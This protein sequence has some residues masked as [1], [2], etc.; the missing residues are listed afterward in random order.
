MEGRRYLEYHSNRPNFSHSRRTVGG[1][2]YL[3]WHTSSLIFLSPQG[4]QS[5]ADGTLRISL[6][7]SSSTFS[8]LSQAAGH[9]LSVLY[10]NV[11]STR[12]AHI[13]LKSVHIYWTL[14]Y[15]LFFLLHYRNE[16]T[17]GL[18]G[19]QEWGLSLVTF[20]TGT[21]YHRQPSSP[22]CNRINP[23]VWQHCKGLW[24]DVEEP[25]C[26]K[27]NPIN[28]KWTST[29]VRFSCRLQVCKLQP[30]LTVNT[31]TFSFFFLKHFLASRM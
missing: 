25:S 12:E 8:S 5:E 22:I 3:E 14:P 10:K 9:K 4:G 2:R 21:P 28:T 27:I 6:S 1:R 23:Y 7:R 29:H 17:T 24:L 13:L 11:P 15:L 20:E 30:V 19:S 18:R 31:P 26:R 16:C